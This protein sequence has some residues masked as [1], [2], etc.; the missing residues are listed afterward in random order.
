MAASMAGFGLRRGAGGLKSEQVEAESPASCVT[1]RVGARFMC[2][3]SSCVRY[4]RQFNMIVDTG[5]HGSVAMRAHGSD[6]YARPRRRRGGSHRPASRCGPC[7]C[8]RSPGTRAVTAPVKSRTYTLRWSSPLV[9]RCLD[10]AVT[11]DTW[12]SLTWTCSRGRRR[13]SAREHGTGNGRDGHT[14]V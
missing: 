7:G 14:E 10:P 9:P 3:T 11:S 4:E 13:L 5:A 2:V 1:S 8:A 12:L 6:S